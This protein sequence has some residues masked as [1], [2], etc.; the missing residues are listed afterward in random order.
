[1]SANPITKIVLQKT[2]FG[3][4]SHDLPS[5][6]NFIP[7]RLLARLNKRLQTQ[8]GFESIHIR[9]VKQNGFTHF[10]G[11]LSAQAPERDL[12]TL[13]KNDISIPFSENTPGGHHMDNENNAAVSDVLHVESE[14]T[15]NLVARVLQGILYRHLGCKTALTIESLHLTHEDSAFR[16]QTSLDARIDQ[17]ELKALLEKYNAM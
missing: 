12:E 17:E 10:I 11:T 3:E 5:V 13:L 8:I 15:K 6:L 2:L 4:G 9:I 7:N 16:L 14:F 1:M